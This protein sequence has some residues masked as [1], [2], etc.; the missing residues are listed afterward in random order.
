VSADRARGGALAVPLLA[1][2]WGLNWPA[3]RIALS[4]LTPWSLRAIGLGCGAAVLATRV[5]LPR[6]ADPCDRRPC[7]VFDRSRRPTA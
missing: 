6:S 1:L 7:E 2:L 3:V 5:R 4:G